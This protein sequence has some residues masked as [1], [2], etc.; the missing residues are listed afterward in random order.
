MS[1]ENVEIVRRFFESY[2]PDDPVEA[3]A[4]LAPDVVYEVGQEVPARGRDEVAAMWERWRSSWGEIEMTPAEFIDAGDHVIVEVHYSG[5]GRGSG[6]EFDA[7]T[8]DV[9]TVRDGLCVR[10]LEF[11]ERSQALEAAG[12]SG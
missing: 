3:L 2:R 7:L 10:K 6:I 12:L 11:N 9:Y 4:Y 5:R 1:Q 8:Y